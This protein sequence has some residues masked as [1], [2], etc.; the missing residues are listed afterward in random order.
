MRK[1]SIILAAAILAAG[2]CA[3]DDQPGGPKA[4]PPAGP[5]A[6]AGVLTENKPDSATIWVDGEDSPVKFAFGDG[7]DKTV[8]GFPPKG[9]GIFGVSRVR[10]TYAKGDDGNKLLTIAKDPPVAKG[11]VTGTV[12]FSNDFWVAV[13][14]K[15]GPLDGYAINWPPGEMVAKLKS[16][17]KGDAVTIQFHTD[18][19][20]HRIDSL[21]VLPAQPQPA[22]PPDHAAPAVA[23]KTP[24]SRPEAATSQPAADQAADKLKLAQMYLDGGMKDKAREMLQEVI[25]QSPDSDAAKQAQAKLKDLGG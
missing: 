17:Q 8:F 15:A 18:F 25:R 9:K 23:A 1:A 10:F 3:A 4:P 7:F 6:A 12:L 22:G 20:R 16:L 5:I 21:R 19:E 2:V 24:A 14:P 13:K 11:T